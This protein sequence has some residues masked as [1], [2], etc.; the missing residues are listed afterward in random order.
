MA[1]SVMTGSTSHEPV[2]VSPFVQPSSVIGAN[3]HPE[4][5][6]KIQR[7]FMDGDF[8]FVSS[9]SVDDKSRLFK[10]VEKRVG[11]FFFLFRFSVSCPSNAK[12]VT[13]LIS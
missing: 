1:R 3:P 8:E 12:R 9:L 11:A 4:N 2:V 5:P 7:P 6:V 10:L 13:I